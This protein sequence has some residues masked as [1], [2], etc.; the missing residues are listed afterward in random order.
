M[1]KH[2]Y[3]IDSEP[4]QQQP[5]HNKKSTKLNKEKWALPREWREVDKNGLQLFT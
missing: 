1:W 2:T 3:V 4:I 5:V